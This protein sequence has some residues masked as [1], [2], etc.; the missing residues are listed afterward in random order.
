MNLFTTDYPLAQEPKVDP[1][2]SYACQALAVASVILVLTAPVCWWGIVTDNEDVSDTCA[3]TDAIL[4]VIVLFGMF[5]AGIFVA[6]YSRW[7]PITLA[8]VA[9]SLFWGF[10]S[11]A[12]YRIVHR[13]IWR[14]RLMR[15]AMRSNQQPSAPPL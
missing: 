10:V 7:T 12:L 15:P 6:D 14:R 9:D 4:A 5:P 11:V 2:F 1:L 3:W 13:H 8:L